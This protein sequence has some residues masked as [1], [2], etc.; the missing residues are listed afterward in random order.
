MFSPRSKREKLSF[1]RFGQHILGKSCSRDT[2]D[3]RR[4]LGSFQT[5]L[6][7]LNLVP[8]TNRGSMMLE[9][10]WNRNEI[11]WIN[12]RISK[13]TLI[14]LNKS[15]GDVSGMEMHSGRFEADQTRYSNPTST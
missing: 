8:L 3:H 6:P 11:H 5:R 15:N 14:R 9:R 1:S 7:A 13:P 4:N 2:G 10:F 12:W